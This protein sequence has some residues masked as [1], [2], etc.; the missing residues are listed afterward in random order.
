MRFL[1]HLAFVVAVVAAPSAAW[2]EPRDQVVMGDSTGREQKNAIDEY[3]G[4]EEDDDLGSFELWG[5][6][7]DG[8][9]WEIEG[10]VSE[11]LLW[12]GDGEAEDEDY[13]EFEGMGWHLRPNFEIPRP[14]PQ[15][16]NP[17][18]PGDPQRPGRPRRPGRPE[19]PGRPG[20]PERPG[21]P[22]HDHQ[23]HHPPPHHGRLPHHPPPPHKRPGHPS[24]PWHPHHP[25]YTNK[26]LYEI[27]STSKYTT[28]IYEIIKNDTE[29][30]ELLEKSDQNITF[31]VPTDKAFDGLPPHYGAYYSS[32]PWKDIIKKG[33]LYHISPDPYTTRKLFFQKTI[34]SALKIDDEP[35]RLRISAGLFTGFK[36][37]INFMSTIIASDIVCRSFRSMWRYVH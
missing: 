5:G 9:E 15:F 30:V 4:D 34:P 27:I 16:S 37:K 29:L 22:G 31:F 13:D 14:P 28:K 3:L 32:I 24:P 20:R 36:I 1:L 33:L 26:S 10:N 18:H 7:H 21:P 23:P 2:F 19:R 35:M 17:D 12:G 25:I 11:E 8:E 6:E